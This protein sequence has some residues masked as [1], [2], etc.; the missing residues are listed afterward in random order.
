MAW[1]PVGAQSAYVPFVANGEAFVKSEYKKLKH[2]WI[3]GVKGVVWMLAFLTPVILAATAVSDLAGTLYDQQHRVDM[4]L[5]EAYQTVANAHMETDHPWGADNTTI[6]MMV[7]ST[8][9][10]Q[11]DIST[12]TEKYGH[13]LVKDLLHPTPSKQVER[14]LLG[15]FISGLILVVLNLILWVLTL[16]MYK[17][18]FLHP[19]LGNQAW[20][21]HFFVACFIAC[22][23]ALVDTADERLHVTG[24]TMAFVGAI[25]LIESCNCF[26]D[27]LRPF[28]D[29]YLHHE[30][31]KK[32]DLEE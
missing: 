13:V 20:G 15:I 4:A 1:R 10:D 26:V 9:D 18:E 28:T 25:S 14:L 7:A 23:Y 16:V 32:K 27:M 17:G 19:S 3:V 2:P 24:V 11:A 5:S 21:R 6:S 8:L 30:L 22:S 29:D 12:I 31:S